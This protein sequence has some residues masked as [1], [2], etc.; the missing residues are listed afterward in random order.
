[1]KEDQLQNCRRGLHPLG[2]VENLNCLS[3]LRIS[4]FNRK[5]SAF[6]FS[7]PGFQSGVTIAHIFLKSFFCIIKCNIAP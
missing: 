1:M 2:S 3:L 7:S 5:T 4:P 6:E